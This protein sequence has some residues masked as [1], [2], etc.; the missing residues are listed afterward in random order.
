MGMIQQN[1]NVI[2]TQDD[3]KNPHH[4]KNSSIISAYVFSN[5]IL[6]FISVTNI[7]HVSISK[8]YGKLKVPTNSV[9]LVCVYS[10]LTTYFHFF[11]T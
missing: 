11:L 5:N 6:L 10:A 4:F 1:Y 2:H 3:A 7:P 8:I 9:A